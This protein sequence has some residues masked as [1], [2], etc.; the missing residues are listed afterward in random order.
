MKSIFTLG[1]I[2][3][4]LSSFAIHAKEKQCKPPLPNKDLRPKFGKVRDQGAMG[5]C[6]GYVAADLMGFYLTP[7]ELDQR[8]LS[9]RISGVQVSSLYNSKNEETRKYKAQIEE[10]INKDTFDKVDREIADFNFKN[11]TKQKAFEPKSGNTRM[12]IKYIQKYGYCKEADVLSERYNYK[13]KNCFGFK[14]DCNI[15]QIMRALHRYKATGNYKCEAIQAAQAFT[16]NTS[17]GSIINA[18]KYSKISTLFESF[19]HASCKATIPKLKGRRPAAYHFSEKDY[20]TINNILTNNE[21]LSITY[22]LGK[23]L[24]GKEGYKHESIIAGRKYNCQT[25]EFDYIVRNSWGETCTPFEKKNFPPQQERKNCRESFTT[26]SKIDFLESML[27]DHKKNKNWEK[28]KK[29]KQKLAK[30]KNKKIY[31]F[32]KWLD[33]ADKCDK[34]FPT[35]ISKFRN[36][37]VRC[38]KGNLIIPWS[39]LKPHLTH[40]TYMKKTK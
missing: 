7:S 37:K 27:R 30:N 22:D 6:Y 29:T 24:K 4:L 21:P 13:S 26:Q 34:K 5:W 31:S 32:D 38:E 3:V 33:E 40:F 1:I 35:N 28:I 36:P 23:I 9:N 15:K 20:K 12:A 16:P 17:Y 25:Q 8:S 14:V 39:E 2:F 19:V 11:P 18:F 10:R